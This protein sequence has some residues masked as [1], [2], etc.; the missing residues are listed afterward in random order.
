MF[1]LFMVTKRTATVLLTGENSITAIAFEFK[2][3]DSRVATG[4]I[5]PL[6]H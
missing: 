5:M 1:T 4:L 2:H 3:F 6:R